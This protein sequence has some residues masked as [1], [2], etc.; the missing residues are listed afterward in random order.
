MLESARA[1]REKSYVLGV[2][3]L[4]A[5]RPQDALASLKEASD[6]DAADPGI[7]ARFELPAE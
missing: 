5:N 3:Y 6:A 4:E 7:I 2:S 1:S